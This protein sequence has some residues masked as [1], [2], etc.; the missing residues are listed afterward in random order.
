MTI[1]ET[2]N[3]GRGRREKGDEFSRQIKFQSFYTAG[4][5]LTERALFAGLKGGMFE[6]K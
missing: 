5:V 4:Y 3:A 6:L 1:D 2:T